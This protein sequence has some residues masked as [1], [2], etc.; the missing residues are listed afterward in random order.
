MC[1]LLWNVD[2]FEALMKTT[3]ETNIFSTDILVVTKSLTTTES[4]AVRWYYSLIEPAPKSVMGNE[5]AIFVKHHLDPPVV[6]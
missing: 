2:G 3:A 4:Y 6:S 5:I 1:V